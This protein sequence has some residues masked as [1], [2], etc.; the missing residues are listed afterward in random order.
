MA[1][2]FEFDMARASKIFIILRLEHQ[3]RADYYLSLRLERSWHGSSLKHC[4]SS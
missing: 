1:L 3:T 4:Y 2:A